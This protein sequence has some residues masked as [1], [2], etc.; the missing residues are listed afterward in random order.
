MNA[1][2]TGLADFINERLKTVLLRHLPHDGIFDTGIPDVFIARRD[3]A[4]I[5][6]H[7]FDHPVVSLLVQGSKRTQIGSEEHTLTPNQVLTIGVDMPSSSL[8]VDAS[9][10]KP[11]LTIFFDINQKVVADLVLEL[12]WQTTY[13]S[14]QKGLSVADGGEDFLER[15]LNLASLLD[16]P[17]QVPIRSNIILREL[18]YL[19][20]VG[21]Q[22]E[23]LRSL[24]GKGAYGQQVFAAIKYLKKKLDVQVRSEELAGA[25]HISESTLYRHFR[26][27]TGL[28]PLQYH[29]YLRLHEAR[30]L[31]LAENEQASIVAMKVGYESVTQFNREYKRL[32]G[33]PPHRSR[34][35][36]I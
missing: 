24:Y 10:E 34:K 35:Q 12:G 28:S 15:M 14:S 3:N 23:V 20:L 9:P 6:E 16:K 13:G 7:R 33:L 18:H 32:F 17:E 26:N 31:I 21:P 2:N 8:I 1:G 22:Q 4:G 11:L 5:T 29:K 27:L 19:L 36:N 25:V 30:R